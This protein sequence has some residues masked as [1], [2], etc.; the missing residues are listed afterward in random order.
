M[1]AAAGLNSS[2]D[3]ETSLEAWPLDI[4][5]AELVGGRRRS[6]R[7]EAAPISRP[8]AMARFGRALHILLRLRH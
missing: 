3:E 4:G 5:G 1:G 2:V 7:L 8:E 6:A